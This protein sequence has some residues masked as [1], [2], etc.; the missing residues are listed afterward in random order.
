MVGRNVRVAFPW[1]VGRDAP[2]PRS[3]LSYRCSLRSGRRPRKREQRVGCP[4]AGSEVGGGKTWALSLRAAIYF[5]FTLIEF[6][7]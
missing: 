6:N 7:N 5:V 2:P 1:R 3:S 4:E